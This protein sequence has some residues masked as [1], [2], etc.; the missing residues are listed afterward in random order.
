MKK[1]ILSFFVLAFSISSMNAMVLSPKSP[2]VKNQET[3]F[4][5]DTPYD[6]FT[7][8]SN[9]LTAKSQEKN[10]SRTERILL[11]KVNKKINRWDKKNERLQAE[12]K[13]ASGGKSWTTALLLCLFIGGI[14]IH[15]FYL[16]Y[17]WQGVVQLLTLGGLG[18]WT[19]IDL[20]RIIT[21]DLQPANGPY[22]D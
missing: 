5:M 15:R 14:G 10:L 11:K 19:L 4:N 8:I 3:A 17:T 22:T 21:R 9:R 18:I 16:G 2:V 6:M 13:T 1:F 20:I 7:S 12:G